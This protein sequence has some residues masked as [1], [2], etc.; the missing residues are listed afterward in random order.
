MCVCVCVS[1]PDSRNKV[2]PVGRDVNYSIRKFWL[3]GKFRKIPNFLRI[4]CVFGSAVVYLW[5]APEHLVP[6]S[7]DHRRKIEKWKKLNFFWSFL[8]QFWTVFSYF[9]RVPE[10]L[11]LSMY[12]V[13]ESG[14]LKNRKKRTFFFIFFALFFLLFG[15]TPQIILTMAQ[16]RWI[17]AVPPWCF[18]VRPSGKIHPIQS[19]KKTTPMLTKKQNVIYIHAIRIS[20]HRHR[21]P[22]HHRKLHRRI[23]VKSI[24]PWLIL[25]W[26]P[27]S[28]RQQ[29]IPC[30]DPGACSNYR[31]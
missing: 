2:S 4:F 6:S 17:H 26:S 28:I 8:L 29:W 5:R 31:L 9:R 11:V 13:P 14:I 19:Q 7:W 22:L 16:K 12:C 25:D 18:Y 15:S 10:L 3:G 24:T 1:V 20:N 27:I 23:G 21:P 30:W